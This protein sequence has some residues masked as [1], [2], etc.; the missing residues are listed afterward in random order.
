MTA[1]MFQ[2]PA[3][4]QFRP[5]V[6]GIAGQITTDVT[7]TIKAAARR[8]PRSR[9]A[10]AGPSE[11]GTPCVRRLAYKTLDWPA[12]PNSGTDP[13]ASVI[14]T[15]THAW[16]ADAYH[17]ENLQLGYERYLIERRVFLPGG[18]SGSSDLYDRETKVN[19][20]W[21]ITGPDRVKKYRRDGPGQQY[22]V[23]AHLYALGMQLAGEHPET[24]AITFLP[25]GGRIDGLHV[26]TE[27]YNPSIA[28]GAINRYQATRDALAA[29]DPER[30]PGRWAMFP[31]GDAYCSYCP[32]HLPGSA[33]L[34][35][36][37]PG[38][39]PKNTTKE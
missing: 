5:A 10:A 27:P 9:Q 16:L 1:T 38:H 25:R 13:W 7:E 33:D 4:G 6:E 24:V 14:G 36:G 18:I 37:C 21:K 29:L 2:Q 3:A 20:D 23:Q 11:L 8:A 12:K 15:A 26:W 34:S 39:Q 17:E 35:R 30:N 32:F 31:T 22:R 28:V 19:N